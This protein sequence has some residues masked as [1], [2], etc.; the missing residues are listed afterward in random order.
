MGSRQG[1]GKGGVGSAQSFG[2]VNLR[3]WENGLVGHIGHRPVTRTV[4]LRVGDMKRQEEGS[5]G[6]DQSGP[7][8]ELSHGPQCQCEGVHGCEPYAAAH[9]GHSA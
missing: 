2:Q 5:A 8:R 1:G 6:K 7:A 3:G 4:R 9:T